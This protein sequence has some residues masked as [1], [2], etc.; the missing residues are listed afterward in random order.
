MSAVEKV[1]RAW[2]SAPDWVRVLAERCDAT[3]QKKAAREIGY[4]DSVVS[5]ILAGT[6]AGSIANVEQA[7]RSA[8]MRST[9]DCPVLGP[10]GGAECA[11]HQRE[12]YSSAN[13]LKVRLFRACRTCV[14]ASG[15]R[16]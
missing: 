13:P 9:L 12:Q 2:G 14:H 8:L 4:R 11:G 15:G 6:Y 3:S 10:I 5:Q 16:S 7:V 1:A